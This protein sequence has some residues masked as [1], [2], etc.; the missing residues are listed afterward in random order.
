MGCRLLLCLLLVAGLKGWAQTSIDSL[1]L[2]LKQ[3]RGSSRVELLNALSREY[4]YIEPDSSLLLA[5]QALKLARTW[6]DPRGAAH[7]R[8]NI[9]NVHTDRGAYVRALESYLEAL[10]LAER[11]KDKR[12]I[13]RATGSLGNIMHYQEQY[14]KALVYYGQTLEL[15]RE[16]D[17]LYIQSVSLGQLGVVHSKLGHPEKALEHLKASLELAEAL[18]DVQGIGMCL[19][20]IGTLYASLD[21]YQIALGYYRQSL[22]L[23][24]RIGDRQGEAAALNNLGRGY[25]ELKDYRNALRYQEQSPAL[26]REVGDMVSLLHAYINLSLIYE[27][28]DQPYKALD[29]ERRQHAINDSLTNAS[30]LQKLEEMRSN[31]EFERKQQEI[32]LLQ[33]EQALQRVI[34]YAVLATLAF[35]LILVGVL[36]NRN[37]FRQHANRLL[38]QRN[39]TIEATH[40]QLQEAYEELTQRNRQLEA[41]NHEIEHKNQEITDSIVYARR[42]QEAI[43]PIRTTLNRLLPEH[44]LFY[45]PRDI[46]SGDFYWFTELADRTVL[47]VVDCTGHGVPGAFMSVLGCS[48]LD[49]IVNEQGVSE[50]GHIV[51]RL[52]QAVQTHLK[53][54]QVDASTYDGM[55][56]TLCTIDREQSQVR[57]AGAGQSLYWVHRGEI[58]RVAGDRFPV[59]GGQR[60]H[61]PF[62]EHRLD[63]T[64]GD[65]LYLLSD[66]YLDQFGGASRTK[67][68]HKR[69]RGLIGEIHTLPADEQYRRIEA[70]FD[71]WKGEHRQLDDVLVIGVRIGTP[72]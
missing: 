31:Y 15:A 47:A 21:E 33:K 12:L 56:L 46:V 26:A 55:D 3:S 4:E 14:E 9:G 7:A 30:L 67:F 51:N 11:L 2:A 64:P 35:V 70:C 25:Y 22:A 28:L 42:I 65:M 13:S 45:R 44:F 57:F 68:M 41:A 43:L 61:N 5:Q 37:R 53:Q 1:R 18:D 49:Q 62:T 69:F 27:R 8:I 60:Q 63:C 66:G 24:R 38:T 52:D 58:R 71:H 23:S 40:R 16:I 32:D 54:Q 17:D 39:R 34:L 59:G 6:E 20:Y 48:L 10:Q 36:Y 72:A 29:A 19:N 50:A